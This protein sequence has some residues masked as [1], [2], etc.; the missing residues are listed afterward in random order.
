VCTTSSTSSAKV[1]RALVS[2]MCTVYHDR[3]VALLMVRLFPIYQMF[4]SLS[5]VRISISDMCHWDNEIAQRI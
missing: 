1:Y 2:S 4:P 3:M 5:L